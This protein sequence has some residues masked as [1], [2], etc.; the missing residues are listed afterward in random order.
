MRSGKPVI[1]GTRITVADVL[2]YLAGG[3]TPDEIL[4]DFPYLTSADIEAVLA[5][6]AD[7]S[8][9]Y[10]WA[11]SRDTEEGRAPRRGARPFSH[12]R[13]SRQTAASSWTLSR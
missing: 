2:E 8:T 6:T 11:L 9:R 5:C 13:P 3:M 7:A 4:A 12:Q 1:R 10:S